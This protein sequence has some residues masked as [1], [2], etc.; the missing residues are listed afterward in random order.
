MNEL[1]IWFLEIILKFTPKLREE[2]NK[3]VYWPSNKNEMYTGG[4][5]PW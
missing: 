3:Q 2:I 5:C 1:I 4:C